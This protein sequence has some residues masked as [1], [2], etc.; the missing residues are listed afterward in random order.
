MVRERYL[1]KSR[2][3][4]ATECPTKLFYTGKECYANQNLDDSFLLALADGGFQVGELA[5]CYF[6]GGHEIKSL[7]YGQALKE[8]N[9]L[10]QTDSVILYEAAIATGNLFIRADILVKEGKQIRLYEVKAKSFNPGGPHPFTNRDGTISATWKPYLYDV[11]FQKYVL[12]LAFPHYEISAHL[13]MADKSA[14]CPTDGLNQKFR[15]IKDETGRKGVTIADTL[16]QDDLTPPILCTVPVD[17]ECE[18][19]YQSQHEV[20]NNSLQFSQYVEFLADSYSTD[21][22]IHTPIASKCAACEFY[23]TDDN[24]ESNLKSGKEECWREVLGWSDEDLACQT[25]LDVWNFRR[26]DDLIEDGIIKMDDISEGDI[27]PK[28]DTKPGISASERQWL[29]IQKYKTRD[30]SPWLDRENLMKEMKSWVFPLHFIDF[31]TTMVAI[32]FNAGLHPYEGVAFQFSHHIVRE[33]GTVE[34]AGEY[35]NTERGVFP[36][37]EFIRA[38]KEQLDHDQGS[39]FRYSNHENT[40]LNL[41]YQQL[42][43]DT[44]VIPDKEQLLSFIKSITHATGKSSEQWVGERD[45]VDL[46]EV[47]KRY[48]YD[49]ATNGSNSIKQVLPAIL[50]SS[51]LLQEKYSKPIYGMEGGIKSTNFKDWQWVKIKD[52]KVT[53]PYKLLPRMFQDVSEKDLEILSSDDELR[54]GGAALTAYARMQFEEMSDYERSEIQKALLKYCELDTM[55]MV[56]IWE[57]LKDLCR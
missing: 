19:I 16:T 51:T 28:P 47:V 6:P 20:N 40:F 30:H 17:A 4:L 53:D 33:N 7:D 18:R 41:I 37:Y 32:P 46:W 34:H 21:T 42:T 5:K 35:L 29:Q 11:A 52:G 25:V 9:D 38:L 31:E 2:F 26:K 54:E 36:N 24:E 57:G 14:V 45:M 3:K 1:T 48:Y 15:L 23:T 44:G 49:P 13:M 55:A 43:S 50:N 39:I 12:S 8:T 56:M 10:L 22:K 27:H